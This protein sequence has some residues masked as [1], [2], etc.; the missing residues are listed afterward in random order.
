VVFDTEFLPE[1]SLQSSS[2]PSGSN[3]LAT[4]AKFVQAPNAPPPLPRLARPH[5]H[6]SSTKPHNTMR[7]TR[8]RPRGCGR[9]RRRWGWRC[10]RGRCSGFWGGRWRP[11]GRLRREGVVAGGSVLRDALGDEE[12]AKGL[13]SRSARRASR[14][15]GRPEQG[16]PCELL[17]LSG[18]VVEKRPGRSSLRRACTNRR[19]SM[20]STSGTEVARNKGSGSTSGP[21]PWPRFC[22]RGN[23][24]VFRRSGGQ[25]GL[26]G[27]R[28]ASGRSGAR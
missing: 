5:P 9:R 4:L 15:S 20:S 25:R 23:R 10:R 6:P 11:P 2:R 18:F 14:R 13:Y 12:G 19:K 1:R 16:G 8:V 21:R 28:P 22:C 24:L 27:R 7:R 26:A 17:E 3:L